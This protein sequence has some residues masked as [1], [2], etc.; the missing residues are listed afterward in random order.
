LRSLPVE[1]TLKGDTF[2][3]LSRGTLLRWFNNLPDNALI[4]DAICDRINAIREE[5]ISMKNA[6]ETF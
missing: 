4:L 6:L 2:N 3:V 5:L 1:G